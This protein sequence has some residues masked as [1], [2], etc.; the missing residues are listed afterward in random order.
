MQGR[1]PCRP[2]TLKTAT[3]FLALVLLQQIQQL[4]IE[5]L[6]APVLVRDIGPPRVQHSERAIELPECVADPVRSENI[7][8]VFEP[9]EKDRMGS[10]V[11]TTAFTAVHAH[12]GFHQLNP[13]TVEVLEHFAP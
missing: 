13:R 6:A 1:P 10:L 8:N 7:Q 11:P 5:L 9:C 2:C 4:A 12:T 3:I